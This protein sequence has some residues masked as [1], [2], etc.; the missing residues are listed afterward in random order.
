VTTTLGQNL[1]LPGL[2]K[3]SIPISTKSDSR[4][5]FN[6]TIGKKP[7]K[8]LVDSGCTTTVLS[9]DFVK[10]FK[11]PTVPIKGVS[12]KFGNGN[13]ACSTQQV[14]LELSRHNY[15]RKITFLVAPIKHDAI[16]GT[17]WFEEVEIFNL[18]WQ[19]RSL[20]FYD[21]V[22]GQKYSWTNILKSRNL[23][24][25]IHCNLNELERY[26]LWVASIPLTQLSERL[27]VC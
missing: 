18:D 17:P 25:L 6:G 9:A 23:P 12:L 8:I 27:T 4:F 13:K 10:R 20:E 19:H 24:N 26:T 5:I 3:N 21:S 11:I 22:S 16:I 1:R 2:R 7:A 14:T 15:R